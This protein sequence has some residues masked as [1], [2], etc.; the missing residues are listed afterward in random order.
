SRAVGRGEPR[1]PPSAAAGVE[2]DLVTKERGPDRLQPVE[3]LCLVLRVH[4]VEVGP[5]E[6]ER[7]G[8]ALLNRCKVGRD[9]SR[10]AV[11]DRP[12]VPRVTCERARDDLGTGWVAVDEVEVAVAQGTSEKI[13][14]SPLHG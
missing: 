1:V 9:E 4:L 7:L 12:F 14:E 3:E 10:D 8:R 5:L 11:T 6:P 13:E 2:H